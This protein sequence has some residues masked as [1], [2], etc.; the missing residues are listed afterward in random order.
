M[1]GAIGGAAIALLATTASPLGALSKMA[2]A[3]TTW[4][5]LGTPTGKTFSFGVAAAKYSTGE[6]VVFGVAG[7]FVYQ[8][9]YSNGAWSGWQSF[10]SAPLGGLTEAPS[11]LTRNDGSLEVFVVGLLSNVWNVYS[12]PQ[13]GPGLSA[14][15]GYWVTLGGASAYGRV[16]SAQNQTGSTREIAV[17]SSVD[18][19]WPI[20]HRKGTIG[21]SWNSW[22]GW[23]GPVEPNPAMIRNSNGTLETFVLDQ[24]AN[25]LD[26]RQGS[27]GGTW[28][29][30][31]THSYPF[32]FTNYGIAASVNTNGRAEIFANVYAGML[33]HSQQTSAS[34]TTWT[35]WM[36]LPCCIAGAPT[37]LA[38]ADGRLDLV[39][40]DNS[41][42]VY[43]ES[44]STAG[45]TAWTGLV[46]L[47]GSVSWAPATPVA[48]TL[49]SDSKL[50]AFALGVNGAIYT[51]V[52]VVPGTW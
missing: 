22:D 11:V 49:R 26:K 29:A 52:Q 39:V 9:Y 25:I 13:N 12:I 48:L 51:R 34:S 18:G 23:A 20:L 42:G 15:W 36:S 27:P 4:T 1:L 38:N 5:S 47:T 19:I 37:V 17:S 31:T 45:G 28:G 21:G 46:N 32:G 6:P 44:Q 10:G 8:N 35:D 14:G 24:N 16:A 43:R 50:Q 33:W 40:V 3:Q 41:G 2:Q 7:G 30:W